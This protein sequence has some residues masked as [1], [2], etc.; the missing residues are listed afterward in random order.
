MGLPPPGSPPGSSLP[1]PVPAPL[2]GHFP[3]RPG[4]YGS[5]PASARKQ[6]AATRPHILYKSW[7]LS[8]P[9]TTLGAHHCPTAGPAR[10]R[11]GWYGP[12]PVNACRR[13]AAPRSTA[14]PG[15]SHLP[16]PSP[17]ARFGPRLHLLH[18]LPCTRNGRHSS[19]PGCACSTQYVEPIS[20]RP[21]DVFP[22]HPPLTSGYRFASR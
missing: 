12:S 18:R 21:F 7:D 4:R 14:S 3:V 16:E 6:R 10:T 22:Q 2:Q 9:K 13:R 5:S 8:H 1:R 19:S 17:L 15:A 20:S 11:P